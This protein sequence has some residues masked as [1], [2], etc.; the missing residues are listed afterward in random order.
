VRQIIY[1]DE[2]LGVLEVYR[3]TWESAAIEPLVDTQASVGLILSDIAGILSD[4]GINNPADWLGS[5][6]KSQIQKNDSVQYKLPQ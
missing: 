1:A 2:L 3:K 4:Y 6:I 5:A